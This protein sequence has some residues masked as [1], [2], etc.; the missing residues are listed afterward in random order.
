[1]F[2]TILGQLEQR[3]LCR[4]IIYQENGLRRNYYWDRHHSL[5]ENYIRLTKLA[6]GILKELK[7]ESAF[8][9]ITKERLDNRGPHTSKER[10]P[11][12]RMVR[13]LKLCII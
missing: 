7:G 11:L 10:G 5:H 8:V 3:K 1:M 12:V 13:S 2:S 9:R 6:E 4:I